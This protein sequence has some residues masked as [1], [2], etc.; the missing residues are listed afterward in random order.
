MVLALQTFERRV[1]TAALQFAN[2]PSVES[3]S[4]VE[5]CFAAVI[6][7]REAAAEWIDSDSVR[8]ERLVDFTDQY[9]EQQAMLRRALEQVTV[10]QRKRDELRNSLGL[11][12][13]ENLPVALIFHDRQLTYDVT[14]GTV[15]AACAFALALILDE[16][17]GITSRLHQCDCSGCGRFTLDFSP[18]GRPSKYCSKEHSDQARREKTAKRVRDWRHATQPILRKEKR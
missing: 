9:R 18:R 4:R 10:S 13:A 8:T 7:F 14:L 16:R 12:L 15:P 3:T 6:D 2:L 5:K 1:I 17:R 11:E